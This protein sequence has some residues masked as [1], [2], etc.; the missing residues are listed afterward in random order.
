[1]THVVM[2]LATISALLFVEPAFAD[3]A[4]VGDLRIIHP[5]ARAMLPG[6]QVGGGYLTIDNEGSA[7]DR[8]IGGTSQRARSVQV[9]E[10]KIADGVMSMNELKQGLALPAKTETALK[11]G[12]YHLMFMNVEKPFQQ[13]EKIKAVLNFEK[14]G[15]VEVEFNI[16]AAN[17]DDKSAPMN[18]HSH[19]KMP[20]TMPMD[21]TK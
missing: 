6:A 7:D 4:K 19:H 13:G 21:Q 3:D 8:L 11:P 2:K 10:M 18:D 5:I 9:H 12:S 20:S 17:G 15:P 14:A 1:M 16:V